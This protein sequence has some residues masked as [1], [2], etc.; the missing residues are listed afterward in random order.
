L[1]DGAIN[2]DYQPYQSC[3][4]ENQGRA[5]KKK[6]GYKRILKGYQVKNILL[7]QGK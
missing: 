3:G 7:R 2:K 4:S 5:I 6:Q 1:A